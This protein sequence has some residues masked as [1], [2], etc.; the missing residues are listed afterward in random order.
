MEKIMNYKTKSNMKYW[1]KE[2]GDFAFFRGIK[3]V[4]YTTHMRWIFF[5]QWRHILEMFRVLSLIL[6]AVVLRTEIVSSNPAY[7][8]VY[9]M[10][11]YVIKFVSDFFRV[12]QFPPTIKLTAT[13]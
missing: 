9:S 4:G 5:Y 3:G 10:Q 13:I 8:E 6:G 11:H 12:L 2:F 1:N 7:G